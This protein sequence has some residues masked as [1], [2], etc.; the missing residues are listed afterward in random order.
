MK[1]FLILLTAL[2]LLGSAAVAAQPG[3]VEITVPE[4][5]SLRVYDAYDGGSAVKSTDK[6]TEDGNVIY[7]Y[8]LA[9]AGNYRF[10]TS[11]NGFASIIKKVSFCDDVS[12]KPYVSSKVIKTPES[13]IVAF[14]SLFDRYE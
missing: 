12:P 1:R 5:V 14:S 4:G 13:A 10:E 11:G 3:T 8:A 2:L 7:T 6:R 9:G